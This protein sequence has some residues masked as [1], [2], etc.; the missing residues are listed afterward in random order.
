MTPS[1]GVNMNIINI[2]NP[3]FQ[4]AG[5]P[6]NIGGGGPQHSRYQGNNLTTGGKHPGGNGPGRP[7]RPGSDHGN[8]E[9]GIKSKDSW[10]ASSSSELPLK[11]G[12]MD[13][14]GEEDPDYIVEEEYEEYVEGKAKQ[15]KNVLSQAPACIHFSLRVHLS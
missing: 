13:Y 10:A 5:N 4:G 11:P 6:I 7:A 12:L 8:R 1:A 3:N 9:D 15:K 14:A 2:Y